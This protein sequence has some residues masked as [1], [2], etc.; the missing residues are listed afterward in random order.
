MTHFVYAVSAPHSG[1][2][3]T[4]LARELE[5]AVGSQGRWL[6]DSEAYEVPFHGHNVVDA[7]ATLSEMT[8]GLPVDLAI[9]PAEDRRKRAL[10]SDMDSTM[11]TIEC[12]DELAAVAGVGDHVADIT[13][14]AMA[15]ELDFVQAMGER[16]S[17]LEGLSVEAVDIVFDKRLQLMPGAKTLV[18]TMRASGCHTLLISGGFTLFTERVARMIGFADHQGNVLEVADNRLTGRLIPPLNG[19]RAKLEALSTLAQ[20]LGIETAQVLAVGDGANDRSMIQAAGLG[21]A[22]RAKP[23]LKAASDA[24]VDHG[25]LTALLYFQG[26]TSDEF[27]R[28]PD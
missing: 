12:V 25:D 17:L 8:N 3:T 26:Y 10:M 16:V 28:Q 24:V 22:F 9:L 1:A 27:V 14:R 20:T 18:A 19:E 15:G 2:I 6:A 5:R 11:I 4:N 7:R 21:C 13:R 23:I